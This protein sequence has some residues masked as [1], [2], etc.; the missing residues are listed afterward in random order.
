MATSTPSSA[1]THY[2]RWLATLD[3]AL[4]KEYRAGERVF[5]DYAGH[6]MPVVDPATGEI[7]QAQI[8][9]GALGASHYVYVEAT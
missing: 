3:P 6:T 9:V 1:P 4:R 7:R 2:T 8:F 5:I